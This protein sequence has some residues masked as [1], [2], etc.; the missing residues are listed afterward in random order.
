L[1]K[2]SDLN[3]LEIQRQL[4]AVESGALDQLVGIH[5]LV[6][7]FKYEL[8]IGLIRAVLPVPARLDDHAHTVPTLSG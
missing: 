8:V 6:S 2:G 7:H 5:Y 1:E 4:L 3:V